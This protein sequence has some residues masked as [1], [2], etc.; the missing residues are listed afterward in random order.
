MRFHYLEIVT[1][2]R[3]RRFVQAFL[4]AGKRPTGDSDSRLCGQEHPCEDAV[5]VMG[6]R[7]YCIESEREDRAAI[8]IQFPRFFQEQGVIPADKVGQE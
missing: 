1:R 4:P 6:Y 8:S 2:H 7:L 5:P 3:C